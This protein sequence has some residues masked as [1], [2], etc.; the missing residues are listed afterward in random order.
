MR[1]LLVLILALFQLAAIASDDMHS[2]GSMS[3]FADSLLSHEALRGASWSV[4]FYSISG[5]SLIYERDQERLLSPASVTKLVTSAATIDALGPDFHFTTSFSYTGEINETGFLNGNL[6]I[7]GNGDPTIEPKFVDSLHA[8]VLFSLVDSLRAN[9][10]RRIGG[11]IILRTWPYALESQPSIWEIGDVQQGYAPAID[12]FGFN[13]NV[14]HLSVLP[15]NFEGAIPLLVLDPP[16]AP[17][18]LE[19]TVVTSA[20]ESK[21][22]VSFH[23]V[24]EDTVVKLSGSIPLGSEGQFLWVPVQN[25]ALYFG[26]AFEHALK[27]REMEFA[28][29]VVVDRWTHSANDNEHSLFVHESA[30]LVKIMEVMNKQSDNFL[31]ESVL[32]ALGVATNGAASSEAGQ[33]G[34]TLFLSKQGLQWKQVSLV[35]GSGISRRNLI[36]AQAL[37]Q[38]LTKMQSHPYAEQFK[39]TLSIGGVDGTLGGR[40]GSPELAGH[41][42]GKTG[43]MTYVSSVAGYLSTTW[44]EEIAFAILCN[45]FQTPPRTIRAIQDRLIE[46]VARGTSKSEQ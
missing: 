41:V 23:I 15:G 13:S 16:Y 27:T 6:I 43:T 17:L 2:M 12:G 37:I 7:H 40:L 39:S 5:D 18:R 1:L 11:N 20:P 24:A 3:G 8:P 31:A 46:R 26:R 9:G 44:G 45:N 14:C 25:P 30:P 34:I 29:S 35:D 33:I 32:R 38:I 36:S 28:G 19:S 21:P 4:A 42:Y 10:V 22:W